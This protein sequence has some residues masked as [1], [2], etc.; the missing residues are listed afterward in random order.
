MELGAFQ[1]CITLADSCTWGWFSCDLVYYEVQRVT[2]YLSLYIC[3][4]SACVWGSDGV[5]LQ[6]K[7][8]SV[9]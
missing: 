5:R 9:D 1:V 2:W 3:D 6:I 4:V 8:V 7:L